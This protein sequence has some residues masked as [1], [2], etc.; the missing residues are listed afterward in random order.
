MKRPSSVKLR[1]K[2]QETSFPKRCIQLKVIF[3]AFIKIRQTL[4]RNVVLNDCLHALSDGINRYRILD[5]RKSRNIVRVISQVHIF[6]H[7]WDS[8]H[9]ELPFWSTKN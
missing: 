1:L 4:S 7:C 6:H 3:F 8:Y 9:A 2:P 5:S